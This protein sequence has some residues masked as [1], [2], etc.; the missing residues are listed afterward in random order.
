[1]KNSIDYHIS[2]LVSKIRKEKRR[3]IWKIIQILPP[4]IMFDSLLGQHSN[5]LCQKFVFPW[6]SEVNKMDRFWVG[7]VDLEIFRKF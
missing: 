1:M 3:T 4:T 2:R 5:N 6:F 7:L